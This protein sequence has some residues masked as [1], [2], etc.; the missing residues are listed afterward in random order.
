MLVALALDPK[1]GQRVLDLCAGPGGKTTHLATLVGSSG[2]VTAVELHQHRARLVDDAAKRQGLGNVTTI[3]GDG[4][5]LDLGASH[6][7]VLVDAPCTGLGVGRRRPEVR[8]RRTPEDAVALSQLQ[9]ELLIAA[10][11]AVAPGGRLTYA[12]CTWTQA[13]TTG[14]LARADVLDALSA[15]T[16]GK[17]RQIRPDRDTADGMFIATFDRPEDGQLALELSRSPQ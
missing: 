11:A 14:V 15:F 2:A 1:P 8:W 4:R 6:D 7:R 12:V 3:V 13:E 17:I 16:A 10:T 5:T 9:A